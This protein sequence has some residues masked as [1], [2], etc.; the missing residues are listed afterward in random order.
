MARTRSKNARPKVPQYI[1]RK[2]NRFYFRRRIPHDV[3]A[4]LGKKELRLSLKTGYISNA[5]RQATRLSFHLDRFIFQLREDLPHMQDLTDKQIQQLLDQYLK[6][7][8]ADSEE[9]RANASKPMS[10]EDVE[11]HEDLLSGLA[12]DSRR[13]LATN[14]YKRV[15]KYADELLEDHNL[16]VAKESS[17]YNK[18]CREMLKT[19]VQFYEIEGKRA[20]GDYVAEAPGGNG[21]VGSG[22]NNHSSQA[23][24]EKFSKIIS[25]FVDEYV[26][27][28]RWTKKTRK[29][30]EAVFAL[31]IEIAGDLPVD[32]IDYQGI[33]KYKE[34][35]SQVPANRNKIKRYRDKT[36]PEILSLPNVKPMAVNSVNKN[37]IRLSQMFKWAVKNGY[38]KNNM[39]EGMSLPQPKRQD[40]FREVFS[41]K[42]LNK[43]FSDP[44]FTQKKYLHSYYYWLPLLGLYT[45][46]RIEELCSLYIEDFQKAHGVP[47]ISINKNHPD[48][49]LKTL[50]A[51]RL[52]PIHSELER[53]GLLDHV[54]AL[55]AKKEKRLFPELSGQ[56]DGFSQG[57]S[58]W[59]GRFRKRHGITSPTKVFHSFRHT[60]ANSLKQAGVPKHQVAEILGHDQ[61]EDVTFGRYGKPVEA[62]GALE[63]IKKLE[64]KIKMPK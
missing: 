55:K 3:A 17:S 16:T 10:E 20:F 4:M 22:G 45:G 36:I 26:R 43:L 37:L 11:D 6:Q 19:L 25:A 60:V 42:D 15:R 38:L 18:L 1:E 58:K 30:N 33:R 56:R 52:I 24:G 49:K 35:L 34:V 48:K 27:A 21:G 13:D 31:Y 41:T 61:G 63:A 64:F 29:E 14:N 23:G 28:G 40:Q 47:V 44:I 12:A 57:A 39:A 9:S 50:A 32:L 53:L 46:A 59:F 8:L 5:R 51:E 7:S 54:T 2:N 62:K